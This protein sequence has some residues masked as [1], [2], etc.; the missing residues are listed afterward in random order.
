MGMSRRA[1]IVV[2]LIVTAACHQGEPQPGS[3]VRGLVMLGPQCPVEN[4]SSPCPDRPFSGDV[5]ATA[6][7]GSITTAITDPQGHFTLDLV[8]GIYTVEAVTTDGAPPTALPMTVV[9]RAGTYARATLQV[10]TGIR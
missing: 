5:R 1:A 6:A 3:G 9:V 2:I 7:D 10:D 8:P 4:V